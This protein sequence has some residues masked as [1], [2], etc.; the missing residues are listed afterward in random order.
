MLF[1]IV[2]GPRTSVETLARLK[3]YVLSLN[4]FPLVQTKENKGYVFNAM[5][6]PVLSTAMY[7]VATGAET[8]H[9]VD[10]AWMLRTGAPMGPFGMID[11]FGLRL[12]YDGW[13]NRADDPQTAY[14]RR[15]ILSLLCPLVG[16]GRLGMRTGNGFYAYPDTAYAHPDFLKNQPVTSA[17]DHALVS[18]WTQNAV[19]LAVNEIATPDDIDR[20][21]M[22]ATRQAKGP[23]GVLDD[24]G[25]DRSMILFGMTGP[26]VATSDHDRLLMFLG[27]K[28]K[29]GKTGKTAGAGFY[30]YPSPA[31]EREEFLSVSGASGSAQSNGRL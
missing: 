8:V 14:M 10:R 20:A 18:A 5:I 25:I 27:A 3:D 30:D 31:F 16:S 15:A 21:W 9:S 2:G 23:F 17:A 28:A 12:I 7:M 22:V 1:D 24:V 26:M 29:T 13:Y 6:G 4:G 19:L 11:L